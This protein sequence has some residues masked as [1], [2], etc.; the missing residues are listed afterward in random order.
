MQTRSFTFNEL[1]VAF[2]PENCVKSVARLPIGP[3]VLAGTVLGPTGVVARSDVKTLTITG[4]PTGGTWS[5]SFLGYT[6]GNIPYNATA[7]QAQPFFDTFFGVGNTVVTGGPLPGTALVVTFQG[8]MSNVLIKSF[9][10]NSGGLT[11]GSTPTA[12]W[13]N[14]TPGSSGAGQVDVYDNSVITYANCVL[15]IDY[16]SDVDGGYLTER[17]PTGQPYS[18]PVFYAGYF[19][20]GD[21]I[22]LQAAA[23]ANLGK[24]VIGTAYN[25]VGG[26]LRIS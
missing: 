15:A 8:V 18:P 11:G 13:T 14:T 25:T 4:T 5:F 16:T 17:G 23:V 22:G 1:K 3:P 20:V 26:V 2:A 10:A 9:T 6:S 19:K 12:A 24:M 7:A 21:L